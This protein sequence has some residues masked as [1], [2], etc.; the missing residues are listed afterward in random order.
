V[1]RLAIGVRME[2]AERNAEAFRVA[3]FE[4]VPAMTTWLRDEAEPLAAEIPR[5]ETLLAI[6]RQRAKPHDETAAA[7][8]QQRHPASEELAIVRSELADWAGK[9]PVDDAEVTRIRGERVALVTTRERLLAAEIEQSDFFEFV[10]IDD[11]FLHD[12]IVSLLANL[13]VF[14]EAATGPRRRVEAQRA[15]AEISE[16]RCRQ[17]AATS[18]RDAAAAIAADP[19][20]AGLTLVPQRDLLPIGPDPRSGL[21]EFV[22]LRAGEPMQ[23]LP[24]RGDDGRTVVTAQTGIVFVLIPG[25]TFRMGAQNTDDT[26]A[27]YTPFETYYCG[28]VHDVELAPFFIAKHEMTRSQWARLADG[29]RP[30]AWSTIQGQPVD[31][32]CPVESLSWQ[33][34]RQ[35]LLEHGLDLPTEAQWEYACRAGSGGPFHWNDHLATGSYVNIADATAQRAGAPWTVDADIDDGELIFAMVGKLLPNAFGLHDML[36][37]VAEITRD[38][39]LPYMRYTAPGDG[40]RL[41]VFDD[42]PNVMFRGG[43]FMTVAAATTCYSRTLSEKP[44]YSSGSLGVRAARAIER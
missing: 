27:N 36:G 6:V 3:K 5:L 10:A 12:Q 2:R 33:R 1:R 19:R 25:G 37:N 26:A 4:L 34:A 8:A 28:P 41:T 14:A 23:E 40:R 44:T 20:F 9:P 32:A 18:W 22:M 17:E 43:S 15:W 13:R 31:D 7:A 35:V 11:Q 38:R 39:A 30:S 24:R 21:Q 16:R 42:P 29:D